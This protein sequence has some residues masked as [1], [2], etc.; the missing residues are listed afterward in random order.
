MKKYNLDYEAMLAEVCYQE[1][2]MMYMLILVQELIHRKSD[3]N[4]AAVGGMRMSDT[5]V[6]FLRNELK[7]GAGM[8]IS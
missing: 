8:T 2:G 1:E 3:A 4:V 7:N 6:S 5:K